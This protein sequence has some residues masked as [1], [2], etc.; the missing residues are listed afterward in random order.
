VEI[1]G[2]IYELE[3]RPGAVAE[4]VFIPQR[5]G[6]YELRCRIPGHTEA[7]MKGEITIAD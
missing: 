7:G 1:K 6:T 2:A 3:I 4:W 5:P